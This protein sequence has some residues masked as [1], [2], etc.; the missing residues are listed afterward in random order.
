[1]FILLI[2]L[3]NTQQL[4]DK[5]TVE[6]GPV[7]KQL[8]VAL[9]CTIIMGLAIAAARV[10]EQ[11]PLESEKGRAATCMSGLQHYM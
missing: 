11:S 10:S 7:I 3:S 8:A 1:M 4:P 5:I 2:L 9:L 6:Q